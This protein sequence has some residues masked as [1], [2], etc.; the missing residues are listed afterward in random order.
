MKTIGGVDGNIFVC[1][2]QFRSKPW[3][4][5]VFDDLKIRYNG[6]SVAD[7]HIFF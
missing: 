3:V 7:L 5:F 1:W 6:L 4:C 2:R